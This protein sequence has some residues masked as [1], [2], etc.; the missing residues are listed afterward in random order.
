MSD[1]KPLTVGELKKLLKDTPDNFH[2]VVRIP[3]RNLN[4]FIYCITDAECQYIAQEAKVDNYNYLT[5]KTGNDEFV[6]YCGS[7]ND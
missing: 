2:V 1:K 7:E 5:S 4:N 6:I 3:Y